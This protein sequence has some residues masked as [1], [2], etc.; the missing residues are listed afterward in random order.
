MKK[1]KNKTNKKAFTL[2]EL[3]AVIVILGV[4]MITAIPAVTKAIAKSRR[5]TYA[6]NAKKIIDAVRTSVLNEEFDEFN[7]VNGTLTDSGYTCQLPGPQ[8]AIE[9]N[10]MSTLNSKTTIEQL[11]E[12]GGTQS[13]FNKP[14][15]AG[16]VWIYNEGTT[17][18]DSADAGNDKYVYYI[19]LIDRGYNGINVTVEENQLNRNKVHIGNAKSKGEKPAFI[20]NDKTHTCQYVG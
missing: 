13:S 19:T 8:E 11:L 14:Y 10:L 4:L 20:A 17:G 1:Y 6:T 15:S 7:L 12:R 3:L 16:T 18:S 2:I 5:D 9:I